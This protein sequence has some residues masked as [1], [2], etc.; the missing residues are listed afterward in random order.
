MT[1]K[2]QLPLLADHHTHPLL[3]AAFSKTVSLMSVQSKTAANELIVDA[4]NRAD[5]ELVVAHGWR[6]NHFSW[7]L[8]E[9]EKLPAVAIFNV[10]LHSL[11]MNSAGK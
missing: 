1:E 5:A 4:A 3:Y 6:S 9:L 11:R 7:N 10:S 2:L 8:E